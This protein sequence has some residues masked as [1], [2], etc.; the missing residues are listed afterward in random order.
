[1]SAQWQYQTF[2][3]SL[4]HLLRAADWRIRDVEAERLGGL[5][6][7]VQFEFHAL[8]DRQFARLFAFENTGGVGASDHTLA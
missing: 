4:D 6:V 8:L 7:G 5:E 2:R 3:R 1:V